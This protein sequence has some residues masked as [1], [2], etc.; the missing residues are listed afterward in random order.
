LGRAAGA[1][2]GVAVGGG[3]WWL[4][5]VMELGRLRMELLELWVTRCG[6]QG[7]EGL[8]CDWLSGVCGSRALLF[9]IWGCWS[10]FPPQSRHANQAGKDHFMFTI[11]LRVQNQSDIYSLNRRIKSSH[12]RYKTK[13]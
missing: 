1:G 3:W 10:S 6:L 7:C 5:V 11:V 8:G 12:A 4:V 9:G 13:L 2:G